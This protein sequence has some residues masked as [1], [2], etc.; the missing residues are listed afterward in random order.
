MKRMH[1]QGCCA[2][3]FR[4]ASN[5]M[6]WQCKLILCSTFHL[7]PLELR[8]IPRQQPLL[9]QRRHRRR[10]TRRRTIMDAANYSTTSD[11]PREDFVPFRHTRLEDPATYIRLL[12]AEPI[13]GGLPSYT[14]ST[15]PI[16]Q[17]PGYNAI[18]YTRGE[19]YTT[20]ILI[21][22][23]PFKVRRSCRKALMEAHNF[24]EGNF[25]WID[26][27]CIN[28]DDINEKKHQVRRMFAVYENANKVLACLGD[29]HGDSEFLFDIP[30][31][32]EMPSLSSMPDTDKL[33]KGLWSQ[34]ESLERERQVGRLRYM[35]ASSHLAGGHIGADC[36]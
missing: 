1:S 27:I 9:H 11:A 36:G 6:R 35:L 25:V 24:E 18:S 4:V 23:N 26:S 8:L 16:E 3:D 31:R 29:H 17:A 22:N 15:W 5:S 34:T 32:A 28:Q 20:T 12:R 10:T 30:R 21:N 33:Y 2:R 7:P 14:L 13:H 19:P